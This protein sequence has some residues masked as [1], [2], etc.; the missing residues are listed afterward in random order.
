MYD[1][2]RVKKEFK[3]ACEVMGVKLNIPIYINSRLTTT[4]GQ[5]VFNGD[6]PLKADFSK[7]LLETSTDEA[8]H[9]VILH[10]AAHYIA[11]KLDG[12][13]HGHDAYFK[14]ICAKL[15]CTND[16]TTYKVDRLKGI[17]SIYKYDVFCPNCGR[18]KGYNRKGDIL[19]NLDRCT[20]RGC[21]S[22]GLYYIQNR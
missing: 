1:L 7:L 16:K 10:E 18:I 15:G 14:S 4:L 8:I 13:S 9:Q 12:V 3:E 19:K 5:V 11:A 22:K 6:E 21:G 17:P 20:C 2:D